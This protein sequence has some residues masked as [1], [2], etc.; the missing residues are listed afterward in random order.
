MYSVF[1][2]SYRNMRESLRELEKVVETHACG[3]CS[4]SISR[5][6]KLELVFL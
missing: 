6:P 3:S 2:S 5:S 4:R 1:L